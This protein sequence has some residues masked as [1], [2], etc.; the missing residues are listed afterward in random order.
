MALYSNAE[1]NYTQYLN[2]YDNLAS[3][4]HA[5]QQYAEGAA[6]DAVFKFWD[7]IAIENPSDVTPSWLEL[8]C[9]YSWDTVPRHLYILII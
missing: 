1:K 4:S 5:I 3:E 9:E 6:L 2:L 8:H 7:G